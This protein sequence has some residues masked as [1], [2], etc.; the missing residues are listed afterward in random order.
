MI[1]FRSLHSFGAVAMVAAVAW[2]VALAGS[3]FAQAPAAGA[4]A[5]A[6]QRAEWSEG[7]I[8]KL[9]PA[10][11]K[12]TLKHGPIASLDMPPMTMVFQANDGVAIEGF[13]AGDRVRF[14][15]ER[16]GGS[17]RITALEHAR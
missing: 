5:D 12:L 8:R 16:Q 3:A 11:R 1:L 15:A 14:R 9:D 6:A 2:H 10:T 4:T 7:E 17:Y 13:A